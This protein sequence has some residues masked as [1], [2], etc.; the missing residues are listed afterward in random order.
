LRHI[1]QRDC[2][3]TSAHITVMQLHLSPRSS[4]VSLYGHICCARGCK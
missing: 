2:T 1:V 4:H 3:T